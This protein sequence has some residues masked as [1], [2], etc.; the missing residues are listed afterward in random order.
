MSNV[1][2]TGSWWPS[3]NRQLTPRRIVRKFDRIGELPNIPSGGAPD[4]GVIVTAE[5]NE[6]WR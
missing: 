3:L 2:D 1:P 4:M 6:K 5:V